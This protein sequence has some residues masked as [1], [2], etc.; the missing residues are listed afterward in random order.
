VT[1]A[2]VV[3]D[4]DSHREFIAA[5]PAEMVKISPVWYFAA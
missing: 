5:C 4:G 3:V 1:L 2:A